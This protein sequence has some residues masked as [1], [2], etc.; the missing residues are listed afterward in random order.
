M[1]TILRIHPAIGISRVGNSEEYVIAPETSAGMPPINGADVSGGL[2]IQPGHETQTITDQDLR[3]SQGRLKPHAQRFRIFAYADAPTGYPYTGE[4]TEICVGSTVDGKTVESITWQVHMANKKANNWIIPENPSDNTD[5]NNGVGGLAH[6]ANG[7]TPNVRNGDFGK[8]TY[9][10]A[11][12]T[13][14]WGTGT[15]PGEVDMSSPDRLSKLVIDAGPK[16]IN[17]NTNSGQRIGFDN[18]PCSYI[19]SDGVVQP[20]NYPQ[21][22]PADNFATLYTPND[23]NLGS[24]GGMETDD[25]GRLLVIG[26]PGYAAGWD[27]GENNPGGTVDQPPSWTESPETPFAPPGLGDPFPLWSDI[28][29]DGWL[30]DAGDGPVTAV[31]H[32]TDQSVQVIESTAWCVCADPS[33]APQVRNVVSIWDEV[34]NSWLR[35]P[36]LELDTNIFNPTTQE[37]NANYTAGFE[38]DVWT[39]F[40]AAHLQMFSTDLNQKAIGAHQRI[41]DI[42]P[43][44]NPADYLNVQNFIRDPNTGNGNDLQVGSPLMPLALGDTGASFLTVTHTQYFFLNQWYD[45]KYDN[46]TENLTAGELLD[47]NTLTNLLGGRFSP[48][49]DLTFIVRDPYL[50]DQDWKNSDVG[51]FRIGAKTLDYSGELSTPFLSVGYTPNR[52]EKNPVEPGDLC[53]FMALPWHTDYNSCA[54]HLPSPNPTP[55]KGVN[56]AIVA[57]NNTLFWSWPAQRPVSVYTYEDYVNN[58]NAFFG[59]Q[60]FSVRGTGTVWNGP[61]GDPEY[62]NGPSSVGRYQNRLDIITNWFDIGVVM[63]GPAITGFTGDNTDLFLEVE[64]KLTG[65]SDL[66]QP[67][68]IQT[69]DK[70]YKEP[71]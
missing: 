18:G 36:E 2:P 25:Q 40:R 59:E 66:S 13:A 19:N 30:D 5:W 37:Y 42:N 49:I 28:D 3:D 32:F 16:T 65:P 1:T 8:E 51:T 21:Q 52:N 38:Q 69:T 53:K 45:N 63:Q 23:S 6:Y 64:S 56:P 33:Y 68:P 46:R 27:V 35:A 20:V 39:I 50:Y 29:N 4:V 22:W 34:Y 9:P 26:S 71:T 54:T 10:V 58:G 31:L 62:A 47:K 14:D 15:P 17:S 60:Q 11:L 44:D 48:G 55:G 24:M 67:W 7:Q 61:T 12:N 57:T 43:S 41:N 70:V